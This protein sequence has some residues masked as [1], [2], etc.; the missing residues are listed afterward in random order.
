MGERANEFFAMACAVKGHKK[1]ARL[2]QWS[3]MEF[4][5]HWRQR[6]GVVIAR[7][8]ASAVT[9]AAARGLSAD[10]SSAAEWSPFSC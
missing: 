5:K 9:T 2:F 10:A 3:A 8:R 6:I 1:G 4:R 7:G